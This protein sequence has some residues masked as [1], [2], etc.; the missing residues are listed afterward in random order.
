M[1]G[2]P[3]EDAVLEGDPARWNEPVLRIPDGLLK[4]GRNS[5]S[6]VSGTFLVGHAWLLGDAP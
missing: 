5:D 4:K 2:A 3:I 1:N 6:R